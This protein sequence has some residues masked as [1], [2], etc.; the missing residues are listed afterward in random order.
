MFGGFELIC[1]EV[2]QFPVQTRHDMARTVTPYLQ[3]VSCIYD[4]CILDRLSWNKSA[5]VGNI[6]YL[7]PTAIVLKEQGERAPVGMG[8]TARDMFLL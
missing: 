5:W 3:D 1:V 8:H 2:S 7:K 4:N 6:S